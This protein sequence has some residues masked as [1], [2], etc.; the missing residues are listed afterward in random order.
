M[1]NVWIIWVFPPCPS[2]TAVATFQVPLSLQPPRLY[3]VQP[4]V[5]AYGA[6]HIAN[7]EVNYPEISDSWRKFGIS[8]FLISSYSRISN[9]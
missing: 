6:L 4:A 9:N 8:E 3:F 1:R 2:A 5:A 7:T